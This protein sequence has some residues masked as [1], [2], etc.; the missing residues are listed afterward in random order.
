MIPGTR[1]SHTNMEWLRDELM[2]D[3]ARPR[4]E[5]VKQLKPIADHLGC[6]RAQLALA[7]CMKNRRVSTVITGATRAEQMKE[8]LGALSVAAKLDDGVMREIDA[9]LARV[10]RA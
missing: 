2:G 4:R 5:A 9:V 7:W 10:P 3:S 1:L 6:T 8:N